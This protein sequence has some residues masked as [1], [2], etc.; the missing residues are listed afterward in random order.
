MSYPTNELHGA[1]NLVNL[2]LALRD[3][4][5][6]NEKALEDFKDEIKGGASS[7]FDSFLEVVNLINTNKSA[8]E[9]L[10][11]IAKGHVK[12]DGY[13][14]LNEEQRSQARINIDAASTSDNA[15]AKKAGTDVQT[16]LSDHL[17]SSD[18]HPVA[19]T[20]LAGF[21]SAE[22]KAKLDKFDGGLTDNA[23]ETRFIADG[24]VTSEKIASGV[25][26]T[27]SLIGNADTAAHA[28]P[29]AIR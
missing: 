18:A 22:D 13:Q 15:D 3:A 23:V 19:T 28:N 9:A 24:A 21:M 10:Q 12:Y 6:K 14:N 4:Q 20:S 29:P 2:V 27:G 26:I 25:T 7:D 16:A 8:I 1:Q 5:T 11:L 17:L